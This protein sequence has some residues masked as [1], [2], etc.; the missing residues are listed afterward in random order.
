MSGKREEGRERWEEGSGKRAEG[1]W[2]KREEG[3]NKAGRHVG[4]ENLQDGRCGYLWTRPFFKMANRP[5][6]K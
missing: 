1:K 2:E 4:Q 5:R 3:R 6:L